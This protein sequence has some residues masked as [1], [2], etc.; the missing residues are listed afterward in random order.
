MGYGLVAVPKQ[1]WRAADVT[2]ARRM[3]CHRAGEQAAKAMEARAYAPPFLHVSTPS[4]PLSIS[5]LSLTLA[6]LSLYVCVCILSLALCLC[7]CVFACVH[8]GLCG[9]HLC[10]RGR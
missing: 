8:V 6:V 7:V 9:C 3:L 5:F 1:L 10:T 2:G 4:L